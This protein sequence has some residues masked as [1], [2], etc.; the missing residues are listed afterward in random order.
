MKK[1]R[2]EVI[3]YINGLKGYEGYVQF[4][5]SKIRECDIFKGFQDIELTPTKGFIYEAHFYNDKDKNSITIRQINDSWLVSTTN[6][7]NIEKKD[8]QSYLSDIKDFN[9]KIRMAQIWEA[10]P[11]DLCEGME[12][13]KLT[14]VVFAGF[15]K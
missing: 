7:S 4:S 13:K 1:N 3:N 11:D 5:D 6:I 12:V 10:K 2:E 14:K 8:T 15:E 9:Y